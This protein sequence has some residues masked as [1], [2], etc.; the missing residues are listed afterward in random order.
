MDSL[1]LFLLSKMYLSTQF[2]VD[3][4]IREEVLQEIKEY[5]RTIR[6][7]S[8][9]FFMITDFYGFLELKVLNTHGKKNMLYR[10]LSHYVDTLTCLTSMQL[11]NV[12]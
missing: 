2:G 11:T 5:L 6:S 10:N 3:L 1:V 9:S 7:M 8:S 12:R 4:I